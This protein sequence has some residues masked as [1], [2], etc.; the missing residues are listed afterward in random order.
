DE[1]KRCPTDRATSP[2]A[3][4]QDALSRVPPGRPCLDSSEAGAAPEDPSR[5]GYEWPGVDRRRARPD[6]RVS[7]GEDVAAQLNEERMVVALAGVSRGVR[8]GR[9]GVGSALL[10]VDGAARGQ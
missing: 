7:V 2:S 8:G 4:R 3:L 6:H 1:L 10:S 9:C 5:T